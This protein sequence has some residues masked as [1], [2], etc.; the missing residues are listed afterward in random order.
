MRKF[1]IPSLTNG[2]TVLLM[3]ASS[4]LTINTIVIRSDV[5][6]VAEISDTI[7]LTIHKQQ[8]NNFLIIMLQNYF[9]TRLSNFYKF[10]IKNKWSICGYKST[11]AMRTIS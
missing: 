7:L 4:F 8:N 6:V 1:S 2:S 5:S 10:Y 11:G 3:T 9:Y